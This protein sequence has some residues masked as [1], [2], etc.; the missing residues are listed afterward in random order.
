MITKGQIYRTKDDH[1]MEIINVIDDCDGGV[2]EVKTFVHRNSDN[3]KS[4]SWKHN[5]KWFVGYVR[6]TKLEKEINGKGY[7]LVE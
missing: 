6:I 1:K 3:C 5:E 2:A 4:Y 7:K